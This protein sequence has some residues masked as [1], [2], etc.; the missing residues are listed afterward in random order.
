MSDTGLVFKIYRGSIE[1]TYKCENDNVL[2]KHK[3]LFIALT[4]LL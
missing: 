3:F 1:E 2:Y 4:F